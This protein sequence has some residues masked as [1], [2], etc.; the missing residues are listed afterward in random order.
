MPF[1]IHRSDVLLVLRQNFDEVFDIVGQ[2]ITRDNYNL[3]GL[4][5]SACSCDRSAGFEHRVS[6]AGLELALTEED[7]ICLWVQDIAGD[8]SDQQYHSLHRFIRVATAV[9]G[10]PVGAARVSLHS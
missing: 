8:A 4:N 6:R 7:I 5:W 9:T 1:Q 10:R 3:C 2:A